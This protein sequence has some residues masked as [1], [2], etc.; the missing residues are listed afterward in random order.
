MSH[1]CIRNLARRALSPRVY[2]RVSRH[3]VGPL[4]RLA[5]RRPSRRLSSLELAAIVTRMARTGE[6][7]DECLRQGS[8][9]LPVH[10]YSP[11]PDLD[12]LARREVW[13]RRSGLAGIAFSPESQVAYL[14][15]LGQQYGGECAW[16]AASIGDAGVFFT[17]NSSFSFGCA[18]ASH[19]IIRERRPRRVVE[20]GSGN[21]SLVLSAALQRNAEEGAPAAEYTVVD[22]YPSPLLQGVKQPPTEVVAKRVE[23]LEPQFFGRLER[24]DVL[25]I[26]S[27]HTVRI[28]G[29]VNFLILDVL[30]LLK[31]GVLVHF[32]DIGLPYEYP[33]AYATNPS[34]RMLWTEAYLLQAFLACNHSF[35]VLLA[36]AYLMVDR[37]PDF[38]AAFPLYDPSKHVSVSGSFWIA[39]R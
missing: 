14:R 8:L 4:T 5:A 12:D 31:P 20:I 37:A 18:A 6:G 32:H 3:V 21:S 35:D 30:P 9:P 24:N 15:T 19:C 33:R 36:L 26:D 11:V 13:A 28:G 2:E 27:G 29:D 10:F 16:P 7:T 39:R 38:R 22:P 1:P 25:F 23:L 34:F 17:E